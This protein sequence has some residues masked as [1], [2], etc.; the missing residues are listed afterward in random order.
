MEQALAETE[1]F[2]RQ[3]RYAFY[4]LKVAQAEVL[5]A[6]VELLE[7]RIEAHHS[8]IEIERLTGTTLASPETQP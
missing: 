4:E 1:Q 7:A 8:A 2:Y 6:R 5:D 3:G